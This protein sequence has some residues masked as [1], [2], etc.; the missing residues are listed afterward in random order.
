MAKKEKQKIKNNKEDECIFCKLVRGEI[1]CDKIYEDENVLVFLDNFP[2]MLGQT[3]VIPKKHIGSY[4]F[5]ADDKTYSSLLLKV[6]K[7]AGALDKSLGAIRTGMLVEGLQVP[8]VHI[9]LYPFFNGGFNFTPLN[10][11]P[12]EKE[13]KKLAEK[14]KLNI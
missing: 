10:P 1:P 13:M 3:L 5:N 7:I 8:H 6:K 4:L 9:K 11:K 12:S 14:I 2:S